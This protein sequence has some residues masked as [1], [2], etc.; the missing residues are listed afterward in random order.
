MND[1]RLCLKIYNFIVNAIHYII[2]SISIVI[3]RACIYMYLHIRKQSE[4]F[5]PKP[6]GVKYLCQQCDE[7]EKT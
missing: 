7:S 4:L 6:L 1:K 2:Y 3:K 5:T